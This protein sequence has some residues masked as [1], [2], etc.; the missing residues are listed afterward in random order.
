MKGIFQRAETSSFSVIYPEGLASADGAASSPA[1]FTSVGLAPAFKRR[2]ATT[3]NLSSVARCSGV[4]PS[5]SLAFVFRE[6]R[7]F[8]G[9][10]A[11]GGGA[12]AEQMPAFLSLY[13]KLVHS[14]RR[15]AT[16]LTVAVSHSPRQ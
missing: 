4:F 1:L 5:L 13:R 11:G 16:C 8:T 15:R 12:D 3:R 9:R 6:R 10:G 14:C 2:S 7:A